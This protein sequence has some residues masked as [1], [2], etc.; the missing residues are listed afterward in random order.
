MFLIVGLGNPGSKYS[1]NR[2]NMGFITL[3]NFQK[4][5]SET[6]TLFNS[7]F[8]GLLSLGEINNEKIILLKP[9]TF[10]NL[11]GQ[12]VQLVKNFF[13]LENSQIIVIHDDLDLD[14]GRIVVK[15]GGG[16]AGHNGLKDISSKIGKDYH[17]IR[18][19][20]GRPKTKQDVSDYVLS[21]F[22]SEEQKDL[23]EILSFTNDEILKLIENNE[24]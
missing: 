10:M 4:N 17:R 24:R 21:N 20:I 19:G 3:D 12:S 15:C 18:I 22:S 5:N 13:K 6:F 1:L 14:F 23:P 16:D 9:Q 11:S 7:K 8:S 2:H